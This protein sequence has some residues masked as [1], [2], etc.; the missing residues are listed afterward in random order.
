MLPNSKNRKAFRR[1]LHN[2]ARHA[3]DAACQSIERFYAG[4]FSHCCG[5]ERSPRAFRT[6]NPKGGGVTGLPIVPLSVERLKPPPCPRPVG[7]HRAIAVVDFSYQIP[8]RLPAEV[9]CSL[10]SN[11]QIDSRNKQVPPGLASCAILQRHFSA[12]AR[13]M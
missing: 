5:A 4:M 9:N 11:V 6:T 1:H 2:P 12:S 13:V 3:V 8:H 10:R 7:S